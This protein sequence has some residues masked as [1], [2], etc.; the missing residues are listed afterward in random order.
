MFENILGHNITHV[1]Q[2]EI[3]QH[4][5]A[6][7]LLLVGPESSGKLTTALELARILSCH[8][9]AAWSCTCP[10]CLSQKELTTPDVLIMGARNTL[11]EIKAAAHAFLSA[12]TMPARYLFIRAIRKLTMRFDSRL[13]DSEETRFVKAI[14]ILTTL[15]EAFVDFLA[16]YHLASKTEDAAKREKRITKIVNLCEKLQEECMYD[17]IPI[18]QVRKAAAWLRLVPT[19]RKK[20]LIIEHADQMQDSARNAF[21]KIIEEPPA[22]AHFILTT[23]RRRA[24]M[25][26][27]LS[28]V[29]TYTF[30]DRKSVDQCAVI[31]RIFRDTAYCTQ[32]AQDTSVSVCS[33]LRHFLPVTANT[34]KEAAALFWEYVFTRFNQARKPP[35]LALSNAVD[36]YR[37]SAPAKQEEFVQS[38]GAIVKLMNNGKPRQLCTLFL[39]QVTSFLQ[40][41]LRDT[42]C[43]PYALELYA[44]Y[45]GY[46]QHA[47]QSLD[48]LNI[49]LQATLEHLAE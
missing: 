26:T 21:L 16:V 2:H 39:E 44:A 46:I 42:A 31:E 18:N 3:E 33:Y 49:T 10:S 36:V 1:L 4:T 24:I 47:Q 17:T 29:R 9:T 38:L 5:L 43:T 8:T 35:P 7:A 6:P 11:L 15:E 23:C 12:Q 41:S 37:R 28:R 45:A 27:I 34:A 20:I 48:T 13:W 22:Y 19:D 30:T 14:P 40:I 25:P 32:H